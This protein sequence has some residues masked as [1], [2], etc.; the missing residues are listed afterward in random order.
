MSLSNYVSGHMAQNLRSD[1]GDF[2]TV[3]ETRIRSD[4]VVV[5]RLGGPISP[6]DPLAKYHGLYSLDYLISGGWNATKPV[7]LEE[8]EKELQQLDWHYRKQDQRKGQAC[9]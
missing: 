6:D 4:L 8:A 3:L 1:Y 2:I 9:E 5:Y 7:S